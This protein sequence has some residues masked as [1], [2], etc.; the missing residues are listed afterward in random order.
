MGYERDKAI[1]YAEKYWDRPCDDG[2]FWLT[3]DVVN[4]AQKRKEL[5]APEAEGWEPRFVK[6]INGAEEAVFRRKVGS[7]F[8][9]RQIQPWEGLADCAHYL[10]RCLTTGGAAV[11][12]RGVSSLVNTLQGRSDT[13]TLVEKA[14][15]AG[16]QRIID[17]GIFKKGDMFGYF[18]TSDQGDYGG[19]KRYTHSTMFTGKLD[20]KDVG[21]VT[22]HTKSRFGG[23]SEHFDE[24]WLNTDYAYT[25]IHFTSDDSPPDPT[26]AA[27]L[28]G[29]WKLTYGATTEYY[30]I[31]KDGRARYTLTAPKSKNELMQGSATG[32]AYWFQQLDKVTFIWRKT[33]TVEVWSRNGD[34]FGSTI[35]GSTT[36]K[37]V[38]LF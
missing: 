21:R 4:V 14:D 8:E 7:H 1:Q 33:G 28:A 31:L 37:A 23:K 15:K 34:G 30:Y 13:K 6:D 19:A 5:K 22:C 11:N 3:N 9:Q 25:L 32:T 29:W 17:T 2:V 10:S 24:W 18:N 27:R 20:A 38:K 16:G 36:G 26:M 12:E 35:N